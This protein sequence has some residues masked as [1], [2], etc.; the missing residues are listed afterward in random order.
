MKRCQFEMDPSIVFHKG[1]AGQRM[2]GCSAAARE[3][4]HVHLGFG[5]TSRLAM[6]YLHY[7]EHVQDNYMKHLLMNTE[8]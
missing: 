4:W 1:M 5:L 3:M 2:T 8:L 6:W 7:C